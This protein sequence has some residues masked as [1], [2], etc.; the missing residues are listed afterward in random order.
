MVTEEG[1]VMK[2]TGADALAQNAV[3]ESPNK[4][5]GNMMR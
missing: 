3:T 2:L 4:Y 1:F 5:F